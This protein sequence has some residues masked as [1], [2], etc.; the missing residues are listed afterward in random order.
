MDEMND[1]FRFIGH[2]CVHTISDYRAQGEVRLRWGR[3]E[4]LLNVDARV[5]VHGLR[6]DEMEQSRRVSR[7]VRGQGRCR[8]W[9]F[10]GSGQEPALPKVAVTLNRAWCIC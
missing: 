6:L 4:P 7:H 5:H 3:H 8:A 2:V 1:I 9:E 10:H